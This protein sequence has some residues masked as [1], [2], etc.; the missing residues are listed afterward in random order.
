[1][2]FLPHSLRVSVAHFAAQAFPAQNE[3]KT[4]LFL[5]LQN[6]LNAGNADS[7]HQ[8]LA[9]LLPD[10]GGNAP[11][12]AVGN[13]AVLVNRAEVAPSSH[14]PFLQVE[15]HA[16]R[17]EHAAPDFILDRVKSEQTQVRRA[18]A[19]RKPKGQRMMRAKHGL[20]SQ[21]V[22]IGFVS[23]FQFGFATFCHWQPTKS[24]H[25]QQN[26]LGFLIFFQQWFDD[27][28]VHLYSPLILVD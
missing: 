28:E 22:H 17:G 13:H 6:D 5:D 2:G 12:A 23:A 26:N 14:I 25:D 4:V 3:H 16:K 21:C 7:L 19:W 20:D 8:F 9:E 27:V 24:V 15:I 10:F 1:V 18:T 11:R